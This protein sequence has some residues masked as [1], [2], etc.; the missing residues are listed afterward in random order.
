[1][2]LEEFFSIVDAIKPNENGCKIWPKS[3]TGTGYA[4][5]YI[6]GKSRVASRIILEK[7]LN[8]PIQKNKC[9]CHTCDNPICVSSDHLWE[10]THKDNMAD[11]ASKLRSAMLKPEVKKKHKISMESQPIREKIIKNIKRGNDHYT[12][13][14]GY[15]VNN[16]PMRRPEIKEKFIGSNNPNSKPV[17][18]LDQGLI[19]GTTKE[20]SVFYNIHYQSISAV[21]C[22]KWKQAKGHRFAY[23][24]S[25]EG[26]EA[27]TNA[28]KKK[29]FINTGEVNGFVSLSAT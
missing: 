9:A 4:G 24:D 6:P 3:L 5:A 29:E 23:L 26:R 10:G 1:M 19:F 25:P 16:H 13:K 27:A 28:I 18:E 17:V 14:E 12:R 15:D 7:K 21:C 2:T 22:G 11:M 8:R 20:A